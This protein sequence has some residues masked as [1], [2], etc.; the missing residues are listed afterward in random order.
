MWENKAFEL[1][2]D[3]IEDMDRNEMPS[4]KSFGCLLEFLMVSLTRKKNS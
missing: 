2:I 1:S 4:A 3:Y